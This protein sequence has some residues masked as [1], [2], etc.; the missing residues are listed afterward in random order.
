[1]CTD[2]HAVEDDKDGSDKIDSVVV[3]IMQQRANCTCRVSLKNIQGS[4]TVRMRKWSALSSSAPEL[5][6]CGLAI[7]VYHLKPA[8]TKQK[9]YPINCTSGTDYRVINL[10]KNEVIDLKSRI[11]GGSLQED[12]VCRYIETT[13]MQ[14]T[15]ESATTTYENKQISTEE[16]ASTTVTKENFETSTETTKGFNKRKRRNFTVN[17]PNSSMSLASCKDYKQ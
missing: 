3:R 5:Q 11:I 10:Q 2:Q 13:L 9:S 12:T 14:T 1:M 4:N 17:I 16:M 15:Y 8:G 7:D 6:N